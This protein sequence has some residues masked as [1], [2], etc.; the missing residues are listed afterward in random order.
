M[1][2]VKPKKVADD[3]QDHGDQAGLEG[4]EPAALSAAPHGAPPRS[5]LRRSV[6]GHVPWLPGGLPITVWPAT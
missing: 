1:S 6:L 2:F 3:D 5:S 4:G